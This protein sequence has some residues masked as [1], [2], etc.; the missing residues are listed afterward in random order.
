MSAM[1]WRSYTLSMQLTPFRIMCNIIL[2]VANITL[3]M[4]ENGMGDGNVEITFIG[5]IY[6]MSAS[7]YFVPEGQS[8]NRRQS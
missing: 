3:Y 7:I 4:E 5:E 6:I 8:L 2:I 1:T